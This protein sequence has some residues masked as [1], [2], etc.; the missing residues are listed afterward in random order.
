MGR[1]VPDRLFLQRSVQIAN[2]FSPIGAFRSF[3]SSETTTW[4]SSPRTTTNGNGAGRP[5]R[6]GRPRVLLTTSRSWLEL[7]PAR[8][9]FLSRMLLR[10]QRAYQGLFAVLNVLCASISS[11]LQFVPAVGS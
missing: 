6:S 1:R 7:L 4:R 8:V 2:L 10:I 11:S 9:E 5:F 3:G